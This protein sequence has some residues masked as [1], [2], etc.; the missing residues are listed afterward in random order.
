MAIVIA[1]LFALFTLVFE[2][3]RLLIA[4]Q[5]IIAASQRAGEAGLSYLADYARNRSD[6]DKTIL[7]AR[8]N[9]QVWAPFYDEATGIPKFIRQQMLRYLQINLRDA[10]NLIPAASIDKIGVNGF[11]F[12]YKEANWPTSTLGARLQIT[13][14]VPLMLLSGLAPSIPITVDTTSIVSLEEIIGIPT[15]GGVLDPTTGLP[16]GVD[17]SE[18]G[19]GGSASEFGVIAGQIEGGRPGWVEPF[20]GFNQ[21]RLSLLAQAWGC[22]KVPEPGYNYALGRHAGMDLSVPENTQLF[23]VA[24]GQ[25]AYTGPYPNSLKPIGN[26]T[27]ILQTDDG[28]MVSYLHMLEIVVKVGQRVEPGALLGTSDGD[29]RKHGALAGLSSG[30]HLHLQVATGGPKTGIN[31]DFPYDIDPLPIMGFPP[32]LSRPPT[33]PKQQCVYGP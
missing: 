16:I 24:R 2:V 20:R 9:T 4:R 13:V 26:F 5:V 30:P 17:I 31:Y 32:G 10:Q 22:P 11:G 3:G 19:A 29:P 1:L 18:I 15:A 25:I 8:R 7:A 33:G 14:D 27:V 12:P 23:A 28:F 21:G 6:F